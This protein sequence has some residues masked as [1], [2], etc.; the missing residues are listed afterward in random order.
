ML[1][2]LEL[3]QETNSYVKGVMGVEIADISLGAGSPVTQLI[4]RIDIVGGFL[5]NQF[6]TYFPYIIVS[7]YISFFLL[8]VRTMSVYVSRKFNVE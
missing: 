2:S 5:P 7:V 8:M 3:Q 6:I 1:K 4:Y